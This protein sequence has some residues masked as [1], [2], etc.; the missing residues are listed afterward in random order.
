MKKE[1]LIKELEGLKGCFLAGGALTSLYTRREVNDY[2]I[3]PK[4]HK[5]M[6]EACRWAFN[7]KGWIVY[8][9]SRA[10]TF[11]FNGDDEDTPTVQIMTFSQYKKPEDIFRGFDFTINMAAIDLDSGKEFLHPDFLKHNSQRFLSFNPKTKFPFASMMRVNKYKERGYTIG[12]AETFKII[13]ACN[14]VNLESWEDL[15]EQIGG[16]YGD[17][18]DI[19][20]KEKFSIK[21]AIRAMGEIKPSESYIEEDILSED[22]LDVFFWPEDKKIKI[23][24]G[25]YFIRGDYIKLHSL[26]NGMKEKIKKLKI[27]EVSDKEAFGE[28]LYKVVDVDTDGIMRSRHNKTFVY[29]VNNTAAS[30]HPYI[31]CGV[32]SKIS[33]FTYYHWPKI[34]SGEMA[35]IELK[36]D[37]E[38]VMSKISNSQTKV[39]LKKC[40]VKRVVPVEEVAKIVGVDLNSETNLI[41]VF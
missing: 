10:I 28:Y 8:R 18:V 27:K 23:N 1:F 16:V 7:N 31:Y 11:K 39:Q 12:Q 25:S 5:A 2:D 29:S 14:R 32:K 34:K 30:L 37:D 19:P 36:Y 24:N 26:S 38:D 35:V 20:D 33:H 21:R 9:S 13:L 4:N 40:L 41:N 3:Y 22:D 15:K 17:S 6:I